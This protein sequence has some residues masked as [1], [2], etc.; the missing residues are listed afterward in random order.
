MHTKIVHFL[1]TVLLFETLGIKVDKFLA[2][3]DGLREKIWKK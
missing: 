2:I 3:K 1:K